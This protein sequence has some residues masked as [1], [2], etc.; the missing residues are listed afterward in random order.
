MGRSRNATSSDVMQLLSD[1]CRRAGL[2]LTPP[3]VEVLRELA[4]SGQDATAENIH[5]RLR[6]RLPTLS[7]STVRRTLKDLERFGIVH[8]IG[9]PDKAA[10]TSAGA[11]SHGALTERK[12]EPRLRVSSKRR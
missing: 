7:R 2:R 10:R 11:R 4:R 9:G 12:G 6:T 3:R 8:E 1:I 5:F